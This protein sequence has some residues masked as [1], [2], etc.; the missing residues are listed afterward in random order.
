MPQGFMC[1]YHIIKFPKKWKTYSN[2]VITR[3]HHGSFLSASAFVLWRLLVV[4]IWDMGSSFLRSWLNCALIGWTV[5]GSMPFFNHYNSHLHCAQEIHPT[6]SQS[7]T[8]PPTPSH[9]YLFDNKLIHSIYDIQTSDSYSQYVQSNN[10][11]QP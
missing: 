4:Q 9:R 10:Y 2:N 8:D 3:R 6:S 7:N 11:K 5:N 1:P